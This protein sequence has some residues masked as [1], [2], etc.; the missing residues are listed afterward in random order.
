MLPAG[1]AA[2]VR[3]HAREAGVTISAV[4][5]QALEEFLARRRDHPRR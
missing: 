3:E 5:A 1:L 2:R 4:A